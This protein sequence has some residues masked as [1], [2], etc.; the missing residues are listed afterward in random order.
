[1][2]IEAGDRTAVL[3]RIALIASLGINLFFTGLLVGV[4]FAPDRFS[5]TR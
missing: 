2:V 4:R 3:P 1:L 5:D